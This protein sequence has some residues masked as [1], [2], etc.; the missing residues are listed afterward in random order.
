MRFSL[1]WTPVFVRA[2]LH[3]EFVGPKSD[4]LLGAEAAYFNSRK[5]QQARHDAQ[6]RRKQRQ[7]DAPQQVDTTDVNDVSSDVYAY[8]LAKNELRGDFSRAHHA[9]A[10]QRAT[11]DAR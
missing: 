7:R 10:I 2:V 3:K 6:R 5:Q 1:S 11:T 8:D 4:K 9:L